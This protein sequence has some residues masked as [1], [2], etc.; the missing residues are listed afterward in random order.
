MTRP[1]VEPSLGI[2]FGTTNTVAV[3]FGP[4]GRSQPLIFD[5]SFLLPSAVFAQ[6]DGRILVGRDAERSA[7]LDP[8]RFEPNPKR[9]LADGSVLLG[10]REYRATDLAG[11]V[12]RHVA[13]EAARVAG[14]LPARTVLTHPA[15]W[16]AS[17]LGLLTAA[18]ASAGLHAVTLVPEPVAAAAYFTAARGQAAGPGAAAVVYDL[19]GGTFDTTILRLGVDQRW[20]VLACEGLA[21]LGG[22][23][24]DAAILT[25]LATT[26][27]AKDE[28]L[29]ERL[30]RPDV[31]S[32]DPA[33]AAARRQR[34]ILLDDVRS[35][36]EQLSRSSSAGIHVPLFDLDVH[37]TREEFERIARPYLE[38]TID[39]T[40]ATLQ[41]TGLRPDQ[42][43][44]LFMVGGSS[45]IPLAGTL[46]HQRL[47]IAP[48]VIEQPE[49]VVAQGTAHALSGGVPDPMA[50]PGGSPAPAPTLPLPTPQATTPLPP[51]P[52]SVWSQT[53]PSQPPPTIPMPTQPT[54]SYPP[55]APP[56][57]PATG[58]PATGSPGGSPRRRR[59]TPLLVG[60]A[61]AVV[62]LLIA[63]GLG[64]RGLLSDAASEAGAAPGDSTVSTATPDAGN[65]KAGSPRQTV[66]VNKP[67]WYGQ[68]KLT[69]E[70][71]KYDAQQTPTL[72]VTVLVEN[73][74]SQS[75]SPGMLMKFSVGGMDAVL[76]RTDVLSVGAGQ[77]TRFTYQGGYGKITG[78]IANG[79]FT[80]GSAAEAQAIVPVGKGKYVS[81]QPQTVLKNRIVKFRDLK[82]TFV[83][84]EVRGGLLKSGS[85]ADKGNRTLGCTLTA[86]YVGAASGSFYFDQ[87]ALVLGLPDGTET[88]PTAPPSELLN[89]SAVHRNI[90]V[91]FMI[92]ASAKGT[93]K[94]RLVDLRSGEVRAADK[95]H[96]TPIKIS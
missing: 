17:R 16:G 70:Q 46:L 34:R 32:G 71:V 33:A 19:G 48:T 94:L 72:S 86:Q 65:A 23:D 28:R 49:L 59:R 18:A 22:V 26:V 76:S 24:L 66:K 7:R 31:Q 85:Q 68:F 13:D 58:T 73:Q 87:D 2:D 60:A 44:G 63:A 9:C 30:V 92:P 51:A 84:C 82:V 25:H 88:E 1:A 69:F 40:V 15:N 6:P 77:K 90:Y 41:H 96:E 56:G 55:P 20:E 45:R 36:K 5:D 89:D 14:R 93:Y 64:A 4:D 91:G 62:V 80:I 35:A 52:F 83:K 67:A 81:Y 29:W 11:A 12:L 78:S 79:V 75:A 47:G 57:T 95:V 8:A 43:A 50:A 42:I 38:Q 27:G 61:V 10:T 74:G 53:P 39:R 21:T 37:L 3:L 54:V